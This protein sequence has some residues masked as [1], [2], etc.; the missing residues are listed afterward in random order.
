MARAVSDINASDSKE[1]KMNLSGIV[2]AHRAPHIPRETLSRDSRERCICSATAASCSVATGSANT[3]SC[4]AAVGSTTAA[5]CP[6]IVDSAIA[7][8]CPASVDSS[9]AASCSLASN[10]SSTTLDG[11][12][13]CSRWSRMKISSRC[14]IFRE[15]VEGFLTEFGRQSVYQIPQ[16]LYLTSQKR[17]V[18]AAQQK[19]LECAI[20]KA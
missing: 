14:K 8:S 5:F 20:N 3:A 19:K 11:S 4:P 7:A 9:T 17:R 6:A 16:L 2:Q 13:N 1:F 12:P 18:Y 10:T 15:H